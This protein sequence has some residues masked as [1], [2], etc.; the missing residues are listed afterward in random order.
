MIKRRSNNFMPLS[1]IIILVLSTLKLK[2]LTQDFDPKLGDKREAEKGLK[3]QESRENN[4]NPLN[5]KGETKSGEYVLSHSLKKSGKIK[6][7]DNIVTSITASITT[8]SSLE[9]NNQAITTT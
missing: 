7:A 5:S 6:E 4:A 3:A 1:K 8:T 9:Q 2:L